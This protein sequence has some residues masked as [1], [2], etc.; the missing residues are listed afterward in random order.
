MALFHRLGARLN[1]HVYLSLLPD[2]MRYDQ[3]PHTLLPSNCE[4]KPT[5]PSVSCFSCVF[6]HSDQSSYCSGKAAANRISD[7]VMTHI[8]LSASSK[9]SL[10]PSDLFSRERQKVNERSPFSGNK[11]Y[12]LT[13]VRRGQEGC[14]QW[15]RA[16]LW[17]YPAAFGSQCGCLIK[18]GLHRVGKGGK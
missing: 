11:K 3:P 4:R 7:L 15:R 8:S 2:L 5:L 12:N 6:Y 17:T 13:G 1:T 16:R 14:L 18:F 10:L 9:L